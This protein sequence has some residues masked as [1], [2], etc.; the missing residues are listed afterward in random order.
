MQPLLWLAGGIQSC[1]PEGVGRPAHIAEAH[2]LERPKHLRRGWETPDG[3]G[4]V[5][6]GAA[7][8][9]KQTADAGQHATEVKGVELAENA[10]GLAEVEDAE[11]APSSHRAIECTRSGFVIGK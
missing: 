10:A 3:C 11:F 5:G 6:I 4:Q 8:A 7:G 9:R 2:L 1:H